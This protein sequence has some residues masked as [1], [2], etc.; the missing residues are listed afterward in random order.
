MRRILRTVS[1]L[2]RR[3]RGSG[4]QPDVIA[5]IDANA[6]RSINFGARNGDG[7]QCAITGPTLSN[8]FGDGNNAGTLGG[9]LPGAIAIVLRL[10]PGGYNL[11]SSANTNTQTIPVLG[12]GG[13]TASRSVRLDYCPHN[14]STANFRNRFVWYGKDSTGVAFGDPTYASAIRSGALPVND[15]GVIH[16]L[17]VLRR[18]AAGE[19]SAITVA[20]DGTVTAGDAYT[21]AIWKGN[22]TPTSAM[23]IG[24]YFGATAAWGQY[25]P[26]SA[27]AFVQ[28]DGTHGTDAEWADFMLGGDPATIFGANLAAYY[29]LGGTADLAKTAGS[30]SYGAFSLAGSGHLAGTMLRASRVGANS[31]QAVPLYRGYVHALDPAGVRAAANLAA[32]QLLT[33]SIVRDVAIGGAATH[34]QARAVRTSDDVVVKDWTRVTGAAATGRV[35]TSLPGVKVGTYRV[36]YRREDDNT[37]ISI[38]CEED[39]VGI[40]ACITGQSQMQIAYTDSTSVTLTPNATSDVSFLCA[41]GVG[42]A[43]NPPDGGYLQAQKQL[44]DGMVAMQKYWDSLSSG[45]PLEVI[46]TAHQGRGLTDV[47]YH[48]NGDGLDLIGDGTTASSGL[49]TEV[50]LAKQRR[51]TM[52]VMSWATNDATSRNG[53]SVTVNA[54]PYGS[55]TK[56]ERP[57]IE[58][59]AELFGGV[60]KSTADATERSQRANL[61]ELGLLAWRPWVVTLPVSRHRDSVNATAAVDSQYGDFRRIQYEWAELGTGLDASIDATLGAFQIDTLLPNADSAHQ[62]RTDVRGQINF[63]LRIGQAIA[64]ASKVS[65]INP[66]PKFT[67]AA[68][69]GT[70]VITLSASLV[71]GG[72][73]MVGVGGSTPVEFEVS[74]NAGAWSKFDGV[75]P[76]TPAVSGNT[77]TLTRGSGTWHAN[78][79]VRYLSGWPCAIG[80]ASSA[81]EATLMGGMLYESRA[82]AV[83]AG[84]GTLPAGVPLMP[85]FADLQAT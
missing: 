42:F 46:N 51:V 34:V 76:F 37:V 30:R 21:P 32:V 63:C 82:D 61:A 8:V 25:F 14:H 45:V 6:V 33:G 1:V 35:S 71:N 48:F 18:N 84:I 79:K 41:R 56:T 40:V 28:L 36:E 22:A 66:R 68:G 52:F 12:S 73:L 81:A 4:V 70:S 74:E 31:L 39:R 11:S 17:V 57:W 65:T 9:G 62:D 50:M 67:A 13:Q 85:T 47:M 64:S 75:T 58:R 5:P 80:S 3:R 69:V 7:R 38:A 15:S 54:T 26:G 23:E 49:W 29:R 53:G 55:V 78:T 77:I 10:Q 44:S 43:Y 2:R 19:F 20:P 27:C 16:C 72:S 24:R 60:E 83:P 59:I